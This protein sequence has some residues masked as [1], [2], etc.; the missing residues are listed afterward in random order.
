MKKGHA[1]TFNSKGCEVFNSDKNLVASGVI[2]KYLFKVNQS[3][4]VDKAML[5]SSGAT[6]QTW[7]RRLGHLPV[8]QSLEFGSITKAPETIRYDHWGRKRNYHLVRK[9]QEH[10]RFSRLFI[11]T[12]LDQ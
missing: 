9:D 12:S 5:S 11:P 2:K 7:H 4:P 1:V 3:V 10:Q 6:L 8:E